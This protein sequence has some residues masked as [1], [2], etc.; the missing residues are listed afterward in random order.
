MM[1]IRWLGNPPTRTDRLMKTVP[2][3]ILHSTVATNSHGL[4]SSFRSF[5]RLSSYTR[6]TSSATS[7]SP[8]T[9]SRR[10]TWR[11]TPA[12]SGSRSSSTSRSSAR[13]SG[14]RSISAS[15]RLNRRWKKAFGR[16]RKKNEMMMCLIIFW[17]DDIV[18]IVKFDA[19]IIV[20][21]R[22]I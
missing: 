9:W 12:R 8:A 14:R 1:L 22:I 3:M 5:M 16:H 19:L 21:L 11:S 15:K 10:R 13:R 6:I 20:T 2:G 17:L 7:E 4:T 18:W